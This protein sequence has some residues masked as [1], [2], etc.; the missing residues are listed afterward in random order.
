MEKIE[1]VYDKKI[2]TACGRTVEASLEFTK[3]DLTGEETWCIRVDTSNGEYGD[4]RISIKYI[5]ENL[6]NFLSRNS[7][8]KN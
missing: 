6:N 5:N 8:T 1:L 7:N 3:C 2:E 4:G